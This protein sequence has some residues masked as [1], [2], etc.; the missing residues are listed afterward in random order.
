MQQI[1][2]NAARNG[3]RLASQGQVIN[4]IGA[5]TDIYTSTGNPNVQSTVTEY[6]QVAGLTNLT[7]MTIQFQYLNGTPLTHP[8]KARIINNSR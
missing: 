8:I 1:L 4:L 3:A 5:Y 6:L 7:G 2:N